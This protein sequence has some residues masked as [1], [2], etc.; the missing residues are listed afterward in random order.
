MVYQAAGRH[1]EAAR[2]IG[3][4]LRAAPTRGSYAMAVRLW[5]MF[6]DARQAQSA[7]A[8]AQRRFGGS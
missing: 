7:R 6:G 4:M 8:E 3:D 5:T 1:D 2:A